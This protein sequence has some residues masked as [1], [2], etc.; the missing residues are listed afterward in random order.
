[1]RQKSI[2]VELKHRQRENGFWMQWI[3]AFFYYNRQQIWVP[4][5]GYNSVDSSL[6][7]T[8]RVSLSTVVPFSLCCS[9]YAVPQS[10]YFFSFHFCGQRLVHSL[11]WQSNLL[12][13]F[14]LEH[15]QCSQ[16][17]R[18]VRCNARLYNDRTHG[19]LRSEQ[20]PNVWCLCSRSV[21]AEQNNPLF[22]IHCHK[23]YINNKW[24]HPCLQRSESVCASTQAFAVQLQTQ[25][26]SYMIPI[27]GHTLLNG[28]LI[29]L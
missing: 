12:I 7:Y 23:N 22:H 20:R 1:M 25:L 17:A 19:S 24:L 2:A 27:R 15:C 14:A 5:G 3:L 16:T 6:T 8:K 13:S 11:C 9:L 26:M 29:E 21:C 4:N 10:S 28:P 18:I